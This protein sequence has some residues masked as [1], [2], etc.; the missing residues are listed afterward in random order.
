MADIYLM[1][2][3]S[4]NALW[5]QNRIFKKYL[6][7]K[8]PQTHQYS[9]NMSNY[10]HLAFWHNEYFMKLK[11]KLKRPVHS[12]EKGKCNKSVILSDK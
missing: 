3:T 9:P 5:I 8:N 6:C 12:I 1:F 2:G 10:A 4:W 11:Y 7:V